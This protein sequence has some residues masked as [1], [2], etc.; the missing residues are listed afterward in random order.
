MGK[1]KIGGVAPLPSLEEIGKSIE[2]GISGA[3]RSIEKEIGKAGKDLN[4]LLSGDFTNA[5]SLPGQERAFER[6]ERE[7]AAKTAEEA[8]NVTAEIERQRLQGISDI[9]EGIG[10]ARAR[11]PGRRAT[12]LG[13]MGA[14]GNTLLTQFS[15]GN[16]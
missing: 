9:F 12:V 10:R 1:A 5:L 16:Y 3:G 14:P 4:I 15:G 6:K 11:S 13:S 2:S 7:A 8:A